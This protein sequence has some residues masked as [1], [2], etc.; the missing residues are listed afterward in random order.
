MGGYVSVR[1]RPGVLRSIRWPD[2]NGAQWVRSAAAAV[3]A[4]G[5]GRLAA[6]L[7]MRCFGSDVLDTR[8]EYIARARLGGT[9]RLGATT[10]QLSV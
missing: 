10:Q 7:G 8:Q 6:N 4:E 5:N 9:G 3:A 1:V 2:G